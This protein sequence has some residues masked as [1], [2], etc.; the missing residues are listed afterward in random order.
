M[1][2][3]KVFLKCTKYGSLFWIVH[4]NMYYTNIIR[5][6]TNHAWVE[7]IQIIIFGLRHWIEH[8]NIFFFC[9]FPLLFPTKGK[10]LMVF[11]FC[12]IQDSCSDPLLL[13]CSK[14]YYLINFSMPFFFFLF[15][16][17][18]VTRLIAFQCTLQLHPLWTLI[19]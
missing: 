4:K 17:G 3:F 13:F 18:Q 15:L 6:L 10:C 2:I 7:S 12:S 5:V 9:P 8:L 11:Y 14:I 1:N 19:R 16:L